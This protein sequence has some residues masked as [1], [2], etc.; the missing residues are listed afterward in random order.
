MKRYTYHFTGEKQELLCEEDFNG[1]GLVVFCRD[2]GTDPVTDRF[3]TYDER[4]YLL[5]EIEL[6]EEEEINKIRY[7]F[8][9]EGEML[10]RDHYISGE[11]YEKRT[12]EYT[13]NGFIR[14]TISDEEETEKMVVVKEGEVWISSFYVNGKLNEIQKKT[15]K[16]GEGKE[17]TEY[18]DDKNKFFRKKIEY[19]DSSLKPLK[20]EIYNKQ[21][22]VEEEYM[23]EYDNH[24]P[25]KETLRFPAAGKSERAY[26][27]SWEYDHL[28]NE[29][30]KEVKDEGGRLLEFHLRNHD[31]HGRVIEESGLAGG[32]VQPVYAAAPAGR[33]HYTYSYDKYAKAMED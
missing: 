31:E 24:L 29:L 2:Y 22:R 18:F 9:E 7:V 27:I 6:Y 21:D 19:Y 23:W 16:K 8:S 11:L 25:V 30:K 28:G 15:G 12:L 10:L 20:T 33:F 1:Q 5:E 4:G 13:S 3:S 14:T 32:K 17:T 26:T